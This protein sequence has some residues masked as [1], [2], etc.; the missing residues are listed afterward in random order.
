MDVKQAAAETF[1]VVFVLDQGVA[2]RGQ[3]PPAFGRFG[4][5]IDGALHF[6]GGF[7]EE[8]IVAVLDI[9][10]F[11]AK[12]RGDHRNA[13]GQG[14]EDFEARAAPGAERDDNR[15]GGAVPGANVIDRAGDNDAGLRGKIADFLR[16]IAPYNNEAKIGMAGA[17]GRPDIAREFQ[18]GFDIGVIVHGADEENVAAFG[19]GEVGSDSE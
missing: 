4:E 6:R 1:P 18:G 10:A 15:E 7:G 17:H 12:A 8:Y 13:G 3:N 11:R 2:C 5:E 14:F 19:G 9:E 16:W